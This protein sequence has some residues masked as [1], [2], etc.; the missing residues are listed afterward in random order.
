MIVPMYHPAAALHQPSL[1]G[2]VK[3]DFAKL[4]DLVEN[5]KEIR[6]NNPDLAMMSQNNLD[7]DTPDES[8][9]EQL[10]LF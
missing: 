3:E 6:R 10:S 1:R 5:A 7:D 8:V 2:V 4:P 9:N